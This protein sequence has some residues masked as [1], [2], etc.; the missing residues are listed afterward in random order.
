MNKNIIVTGVT[1]QMGSYMADFLLS[2]GYKVYGTVRRL[3]VPNHKN[4]Q[5]IKN[6]DF[7]LVPM[8][9]SD[10][11]SINTIIEKYKPDFFINCAANS[12][13]GSSWDYPEQ[14][15][16]CNFLGVLRQLEAIKRFSPTTKYVNFGSSEEFG[17]VM[18]TPQ[19]ETHPARARSPYSVSKIAARQIVKVYRDSFGLF[20]IQPWC[21]NYESPRRGTEFVSRKITKGV[22][23]IANAIK[24]GEK[25][26][27]IE[28]GNLNAKR[29]WSHA[30]D[31]VE[32]IWL[33]LNQEKPESYVLSSNETHTVREF[34]EKAFAAA[35]LHGNWGFCGEAIPENEVFTLSTGGILVRINPAFYRPAEVDLLW[36]D[37]TRARAELNWKPKYTFY[38]LVKCMVDNDM[39]EIAGE[40][41]KSV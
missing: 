2:K 23:R 41:S 39:S 17:D 19:N 16:D 6:P 36:G 33:M 32:G 38:E 35:G 12:F 4:I 34:V 22:A 24:N 1:G 18:F 8:D 27:P 15:M 7:T 20:I 31:F 37:S 9:L 26:D 10:S 25:F 29:D 11:S 14:H 3:S 40:S 13:V 5:H 21:F 28:L 30:K